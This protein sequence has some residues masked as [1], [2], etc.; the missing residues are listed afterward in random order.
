MNILPLIR[1]IAYCQLITSCNDAVLWCEEY[2]PDEKER[3]TE[4]WCEVG[5]WPAGVNGLIPY[6]LK[7]GNI[8]WIT[9]RC[10]S[11]CFNKESY[12]STSVPSVEGGANA[13]VKIDDRKEGGMEL[14]DRASELNGDP[15]FEPISS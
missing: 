5:S 10:K 11:D 8:S 15:S 6:R 7:I 9:C 2:W 14:I 4:D 1:L 13:A 12:L 3:D